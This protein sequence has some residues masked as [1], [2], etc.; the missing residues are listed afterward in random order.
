MNMTQTIVYRLTPVRPNNKA[1]SKINYIFRTIRIHLYALVKCAFQT[2]NLPVKDWKSQYAILG[3][4]S[5][6]KLSSGDKQ[7]R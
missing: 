2:K 1:I 5:E 3:R 7:C 4:S 6:A